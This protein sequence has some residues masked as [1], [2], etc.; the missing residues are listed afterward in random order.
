MSMTADASRDIPAATEQA[1]VQKAMRKLLPFLFFLY[2]IAYLDR[3]NVSFAKLQMNELPWVTESIYGFGS[4]IFFIGYF[5]FEVPSNMILQRVGAR[6]WIARIMVTWG[7]IAMGM[8]FVNS[9]L[10]F[11]V[12]RFLLGVA[13]AGFFPGVLLYMTYWFTLKERARA[14]AFF[15]TANAVTF[16]LGA[17]LS[18]WLMGHS[19]FG[20]A[21]YQTMFLL[22]GIPAVLMAAVVLW[23]LPNGP[24]E[25]KW[26]T[27]E[28]KQILA[29]RLVREDVHKESQTKGDG[30][31]SL[32]EAMAHLKQALTE[33][34]VWILCGVYFCLVT[35]MYGIGLWIPQVVKDMAQGANPFT[36]GLLSAIPYAVSGTIM[37]LNAAHSD[38][39]GER[40]LHVTIPAIIGACGLVGYA[41]FEKNPVVAI[42]FLTVAASGMWSILGPFWSL[43]PL[44]LRS[45]TALAAGL[46]FI[47]SVGNLGGFLGPFA[48]GLIKDANKQ[49]V[50]HENFAGF[51]FLAVVVFIGALLALAVP[52]IAPARGRAS[53]R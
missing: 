5:L 31:G 51:I 27:E 10:F 26:L 21:G 1:V 50:G 32:D 9:P 11:Y 4:G 8:L 19:L 45:S 33:P 6:M 29:Q 46:A 34:K 20:L 12:M 25:A 24:R 22:E 36:I 7:I 47:N 43:P 37:V 23:Y 35:G 48:V 3:V 14:V 42:F 38:R 2:V 30:H 28:E 52:V 15:M 16:S 53:D 17:P 18:G 13:E 40:R 41:F 49:N 44:V 39:T